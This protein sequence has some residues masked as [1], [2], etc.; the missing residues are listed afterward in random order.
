MLRKFADPTLIQA[1]ILGLLLVVAPYAMSFAPYE[2]IYT[3][4][5]WHTPF[6]LDPLYRIRA[7]L[8]GLGIISGAF[9]VLLLISVLIRKLLW[10]G[11]VVLQTRNA[12]DLI[13]QMS[14]A[15]CSATIGW[16]AYPY[17]VN[18]VYQAYSGDGPLW[19]FDPKALM[20]S[21]WIDGIWYFGVLIIFLTALI[22]IPLLFLSNLVL[23]PIARTWKRGIVTALCL[24]LIPVIFFLSPGYFKWLAD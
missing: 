6:H 19:V 2:S 9:S 4:G 13:L 16:G 7:I 1:I 22:G 15:L 14:M 11:D 20:P 5:A 8:I 21:I 23:T 24:L 18:G 10:Q 17:W 3:Y 12:S